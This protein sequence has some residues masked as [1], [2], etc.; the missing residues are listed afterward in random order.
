MV[1]KKRT[2]EYYTSRAG[3]WSKRQLTMVVDTIERLE[4][5]NF[6]VRYFNKESLNTLKQ[7]KRYIEAMIKKEQGFVEY[8]KLQGENSPSEIV[9]ANK[10]LEKQLKAGEDI[11]YVSKREENHIANQPKKKP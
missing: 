1:K 7:Q 8:K 10:A 11:K 3:S 9:K 5:K 4:S 2:M 6:L